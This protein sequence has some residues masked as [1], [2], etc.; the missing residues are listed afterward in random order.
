MPAKGELYEMGVEF[1]DYYKLLGVARNASRDD[2]SKA[3]KK[4]ARKYH[5]DL[6]P[7]DKSAENSFKEITEAYEVLKDDEKRKLYDQLGPNWQHGQ[8]FQRPGGFG[9]MN[10]GGG[11][12]FDAS[13]FSDFFE[14]VFGGSRGGGRGGFGPDPFGGFSSRQRAGRDVEAELTLTLEE[15]HQGGRKALSLQ[16]S[17]GPRTLDVNIPLGVREGQRIRLAGQGDPGMNGAPAGDLYLKVRL[18]PHPVFRLDGTTVV[19]DAHIPPWVAVLG[20]RARVATLDGEVELNIAPG[21]GSGRKLRLRG[22]GLGPASDKGDQLVRIM[23]TAPDALT[24]R[25]KELWEQLR[26]ASTP[27]SEA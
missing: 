19:C 23:V 24:P 27:E 1:K 21:T 26:D 25:Q 12:S 13:G 3:Y 4:L 10:F 6:N 17:T 14:A 5:P 18:A 7:G 16:T 11:Q 8:N 22:R 20:G 15:V 9:G 2:I